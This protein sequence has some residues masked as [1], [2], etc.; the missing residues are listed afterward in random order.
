VEKPLF[1]SLKVPY[2]VRAEHEYNNLKF[3]SFPQ[4]KRFDPE[5]LI[6]GDLKDK[7]WDEAASFLQ[8][9][10]YFGLLNEI[11]KPKDFSVETRDFVRRSEDGRLFITTDLLPVL[12]ESRRTDAR[13][14]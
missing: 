5:I 10:C 4:R 3:S 12:L 13:F 7:S 2:L 6:V 11:L 1:P 9:W 8:A 14:R